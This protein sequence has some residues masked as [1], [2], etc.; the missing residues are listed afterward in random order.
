MFLMAR[1]KRLISPQIPQTRLE[2]TAELSFKAKLLFAT[3]T[4]LM[5]FSEH[6]GFMMER[7]EI[8]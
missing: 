3:L 8:S 5:L 1:I 4:A 6:P 2:S 7:A